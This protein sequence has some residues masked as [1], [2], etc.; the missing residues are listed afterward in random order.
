MWDVDPEAGVVR[1]YRPNEPAPAVFGAGTEADAE[2]AVPGWRV[3]LDWLMEDSDD[4]V[5]GAAGR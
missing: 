1:R 2:P 4:E 5:G 3:E